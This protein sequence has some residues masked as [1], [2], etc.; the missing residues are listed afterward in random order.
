[1]RR[2]VISTKAKSS[3]C[4]S[5]HPYELTFSQRNVRL[6]H[7]QAEVAMDLNSWQADVAMDLN[8]CSVTC[9]LVLLVVAVLVAAVPMDLNSCFVLGTAPCLVAV[10]VAAQF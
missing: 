4:E 3:T 6:P 7:T 2:S 1:M 8:S 5:Y 9:K 10:L